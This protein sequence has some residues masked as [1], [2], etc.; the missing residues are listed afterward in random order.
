M[1]STSHPLAPVSRQ[2]ARRNAAR[3]VDL[4]RGDLDRI[5]HV[6]RAPRQADAGDLAA[7]A[8]AGIGLRHALRRHVASTAG[9][10]PGGAA[11]LLDC[12]LARSPWTAGRLNRAWMTAMAVTGQADPPAPI[13]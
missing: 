2:A 4:L 12:L 7:L 1:T 11:D 6:A 3:R 5:A 13:R 9:Y 10:G 8:A